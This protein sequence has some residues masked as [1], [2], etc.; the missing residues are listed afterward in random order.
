[1]IDAPTY[2]EHVRTAGE[3]IATA[4]EGRLD[5]PVPS[6]PGNT[7][8]SLLLHTASVCMFWADALIQNRMPDSDWPSFPTDA[9]EAH[10]RMHGR[11]VDE[12][13]ARDPDQPTWTW[14]AGRTGQGT[15]RFAYR[16]VAQELAVHR[17]DFENAVGDPLPIDPALAAD[18][19]DEFLYVFGPATG[20]ADFPGASERFGGDGQTFRLEPIDLPDAIT[21]TAYADRFEANESGKADVVARGAASDLLLFMWGRI[22]PEEVEVSGDTSLLTRW[23][24]RVKI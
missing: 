15:V 16:R 11:V 12:L 2:L 17:W 3:R 22:P 13:A 23:Q 14:A 5:D 10:K 24:E 8:G 18:G 4:A 6:C 21:F 1:M 7:V 19:L 9:L 20:Q